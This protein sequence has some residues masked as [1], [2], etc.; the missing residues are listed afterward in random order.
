MTPTDFLQW[1]AAAMQLISL[2]V[3]SYGVIRRA[4]QDAGVDDATIAEFAPKWDALLNDVAR[5]AGQLPK[6]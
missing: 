3:K 5:A 4:M 2:G 1:Q 6:P